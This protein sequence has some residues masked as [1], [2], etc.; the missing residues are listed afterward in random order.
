MPGHKDTLK[1][2]IEP[3]SV[4]NES[5]IYVGICEVHKLFADT[6]DCSR[7]GKWFLTRQSKTQCFAESVNVAGG[8]IEEIRMLIRKK[9]TRNG[10]VLFGSRPRS[11]SLSYRPRAPLGSAGGGVSR[12]DMGRAGGLFDSDPSN[13][14]RES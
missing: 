11:I 3:S 8:G 5:S 10:L 1:K 9:E 7:Q 14:S 2:S 12:G 6:I 4:G 13:R